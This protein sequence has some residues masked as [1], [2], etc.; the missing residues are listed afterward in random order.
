M[1]VLNSKEAR[2]GG[3]KERKN[4]KRGA[5]RRLVGGFQYPCSGFDKGQKRSSTALSRKVR[6]S[7]GKT[8]ELRKKTRGH[9]QGRSRGEKGDKKVKL[10]SYP[11][12]EKGSSWPVGEVLAER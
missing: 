8:A 9:R 5:C 7:K 10:V 3:E 1:T 6:P 12:D 2:K 11:L 4:K